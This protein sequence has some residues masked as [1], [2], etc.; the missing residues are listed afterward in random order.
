MQV[1]FASAP[2]SMYTASKTDRE[3]TQG[4]VNP[5]DNTEKSI[6]ITFFCV[7]QKVNIWTISWLLSSTDNEAEWRQ[8]VV[9]LQNDKEITPKVFYNELWSQAMGELMKFEK[10][11][12]KI[13]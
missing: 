11:T 2:A 12:E 9:K 4:S 7:T 1:A 6:S 13:C 5:N 3:N 10:F 8:S